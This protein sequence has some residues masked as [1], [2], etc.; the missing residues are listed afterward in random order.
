MEPQD[1]VK[2]KT[3]NTKKTFGAL[4]DIDLYSKHLSDLKLL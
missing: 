4:E 1:K 3:E 2:K